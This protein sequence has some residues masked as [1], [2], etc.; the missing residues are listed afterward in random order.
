[1]STNTAAVLYGVNDLRVEPFPLAKDVPDASVRVQMKAVGICGSDVHYLKHGKIGSFVVTS[2]MVIGHESAGVVVAVGRDVKG[3]AVGDR[4]A[5]EPAVPC[6]GCSAAREGR[7]NLD[8]DIR[9]FATPPY[10]GSLANF[11][12]H[13]ADFCYKLPDNVSLEE[14]AFC[15]PLSV[16]VHACRR[17]QVSPGKTVLILGAGPIGLVSLL[18]ARAFGADTI[19]ITDIKQHNLD[20]AHR[21]GADHT[22]LISPTLTGEEAAEEIQQKVPGSIQV[23]VDCAGFQQTLV[24]ALH[25]VSPGGR[26]VLVGMG[27]DHV[28]IPST[29]ISVKEIDLCGSFR[30]CNTYPLCI[31]LL[32][33]KKVDVM[34][35]ITHRFGFKPEQVAA[36]FKAASELDSSGAIKVMFNI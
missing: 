2:P 21:L 34:P 28:E 25:A 20:V 29:L 3:L 19:I 6:W 16:G 18:S 33:S 32:Q 31:K 4:V 9:C 12:D 1:M 7:Y 35:L 26:V 15:E 8:P 24:T 13:P 30:Y 27:Q 36:A 14:G 10:H 11:V 17:G 22:V 23:V 5:L